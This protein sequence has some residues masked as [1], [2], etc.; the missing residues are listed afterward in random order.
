[1][2]S[3]WAG[4]GPRVPAR[5]RDSTYLP[6]FGSG[7]AGRGAAGALPP[8]FLLPPP[9]PRSAT[10]NTRR[11]RKPRREARVSGSWG[12]GGRQREG[13]AVPAEQEGGGLEVRTS[14]R[15]QGQEETRRGRWLECGR[16]GDPRNPLEKDGSACAWWSAEA[17]CPQ[18]AYGRRGKRYYPAQG[19]R[20]DSGLARLVP[21]GAGS[22]RGRSRG[23]LRTLSYT[24]PLSWPVAGEGGSPSRRPIMWRSCWS[25]LARHFRLVE[26]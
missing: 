19:P 4:A 23:G 3:R 8:S 18:G 17:H 22:R 16:P 15:S 24:S 14:W 12:V 2:R 6:G 20:P 9:P 11:K 7:S 21:G 13:L 1:M 25:Q 10:H 26:F 5:R